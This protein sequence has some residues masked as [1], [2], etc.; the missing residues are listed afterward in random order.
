MTFVLWLFYVLLELLYLCEFFL[1]LS[2]FFYSDAFNVVCEVSMGESRIGKFGI[3][4]CNVNYSNGYIIFSSCVL[5]VMAERI[6]I[7]RHNTRNSA[8]SE[9]VLYNKTV[10]FGWHRTIHTETRKKIIAFTLNEK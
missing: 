1:L 3:G 9:L 2:S 7:D 10:L 6:T 5:G 8:D 4:E